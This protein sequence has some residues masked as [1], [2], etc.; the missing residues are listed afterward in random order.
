[1]TSYVPLSFSDL[2]IA[3]TLVVLNGAISFAYRLKL[4]KSLAIAAVRM[5]VQLA[6]VALA[7][8][9]IFQQVSPLWT[10]GVASM[11]AAGATFEV[12]TRQQHRLK[13]WLGLLLS[14]S[15]AFLSG[16]V[17]TFLALAVI[18]PAPWYAPRF[19]LPI[20]GLLTGN[21]LSGVT[22]VLDTL[23]SA[24]TRER[25]T[26]EARLALGATRYEAFQ[27]I[28]RQ[29]MR[30]GLTPVLNAMAAA[31]IVSL[32]GMMTGQI[33]AGIDPVEAAKYQIMIMFLI[34]GATAISVLAAG[35]AM[36]H[37][38]TDDRHRLRLDM[39]VRAKD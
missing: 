15:P 4:E 29:A 1:M 23:T 3:T 35:L 34:A 5:I 6:A 24:A 11:V 16:L 9:F 18:Q 33:L 21:T 14:A 2:A 28:L 26:I 36:V 31:G 22:L 17:T 38:I 27:D 12:I 13:G 10:I 32:P 30:T 25:N 19:L 20:L 37:F 8:R 39:L 7:L